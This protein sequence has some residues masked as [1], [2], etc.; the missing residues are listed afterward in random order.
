MEFFTKINLFLGLHHHIHSSHHHQPVILPPS[1]SSASIRGTYVHKYS[2][3]LPGTGSYVKMNRVYPRPYLPNFVGNE[4][5]R[6]APLE[7]SLEDQQT[8]RLKDSALLSSLSFLPDGT[9][10][11]QNQQDS[12]NS[13]GY[14]NPRYDPFNPRYAV[15]LKILSI[16]FNL[17]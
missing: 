7:L 15:S 11:L 12:T 1:S 16:S 8:Q 6:S 10:D 4:Q 3:N 2:Y 9:G 17:L 14:H 13:S 5:F